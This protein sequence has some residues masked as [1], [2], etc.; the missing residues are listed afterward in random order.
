MFNNNTRTKKLQLTSETIKLRQ[1]SVTD[2]DIAKTAGGH[3]VTGGAP[4]VLDVV[5]LSTAHICTWNGGHLIKVTRNRTVNTGGGGARGKITGFSKNSRR[6]LMRTIA[7]TKKVQL[8]IFVTLTYPGQW[9]NNP[10][11]WKRDLR[12]FWMRLNRALPGVGCIWKLEFQKR[13]APHFHLLVWGSGYAPLLI[14]VSR[15]WYETVGS[16]DE[17]HLRAGSRVEMVKSWRGVMA[18]ASKYLGKVELLPVTEPG[19]FWGVMAEEN[20]PWADMVQMALTDRQACQFLRL[21]R[22]MA[23]LR[24]RAYNSLT[25]FTDADFWVDRLDRLL[26]I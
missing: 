18:Y 4:D 26:D 10:K 13:G 5:G 11:K 21:M 15:I 14:N 20:L 3:P 9:D 19:R 24:G 23:H 17:R 12:V 22:R 2:A 7:K 16:G 1:L 6:R 25:I 8:P